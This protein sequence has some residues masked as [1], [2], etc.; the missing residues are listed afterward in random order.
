MIVNE[1]NQDVYFTC[2][3]TREQ[4]NNYLK[5]IR[6]FDIFDFYEIDD[7]C[8]SIFNFF[9]NENRKLDVDVLETEELFK[10]I[11]IIKD[12]KFNNEEHELYNYGIITNYKIYSTN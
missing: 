6:K 1:V 11:P 10:I 3:L 5:E 12:N 7:Y 2:P 8:D 4:L 9:T